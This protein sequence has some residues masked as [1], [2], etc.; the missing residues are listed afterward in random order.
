MSVPPSPEAR[1]HDV[2]LVSH[3]VLPHGTMP[4]S[5]AAPPSGAWQ[6]TVVPPLLVPPSAPEPVP[7]SDVPLLL[8]PPSPVVE[9]P[10]L[11]PPLPLPE[12]GATPL[13][14]V[15]PL[16]FDPPDPLPELPGC[17]PSASGCTSDEL[18]CVIESGIEADSSVP[19]N[20]PRW[21]FF[22]AAPPRASTRARGDRN[23]P[24]GSP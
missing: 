14:P 24:F 2:W 22:I 19:A 7:P 23:D 13:L 18:H 10:L 6:V 4:G 21:I 9:T 1:Q 11:L 17:P 3:I 12:E 8:P 5:H 16:L 20:I 15:P